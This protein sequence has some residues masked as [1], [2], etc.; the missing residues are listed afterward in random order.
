MKKVLTSYKLLLLI[1]ILFLL[2]VNTQYY[3]EVWIG[4]YALAV[5]LILFIGYLSLVVALLYQIY[6]SVEENFKN[7]SRL[8]INLLIAGILIFIYNKPMGIMNYDEWE[9]E[10]LLIAEAEGIANCMIRVKFKNDQS[11]VE[12]DICF[13]VDVMKG[14]YILRNDTL[15]LYQNFLF[16][17]SKDYYVFALFKTDNDGDGKSDD[18][19]LLYRS[20]NDTLPIMLNIRKNKLLKN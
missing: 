6:F 14:S 5:Y 10:N 13:G 1:V 8:I 9:D 11:F 19:L 7:K 12:R 17:R 4:D 16:S 15:F 2:A 20:V 3:W 18:K